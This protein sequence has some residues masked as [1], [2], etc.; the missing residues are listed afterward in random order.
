MTQIKLPPM[1]P[2]GFTGPEYEA[3]ILDIKDSHEIREEQSTYLASVDMHAYRVKVEQA[4]SELFETN[5]VLQKIRN[6]QAVS[7]QELASLNALI[8][9]QHPDVDFETL[10]NFYDSA[11]PLDQI[12]RSIIGMDAE[13]VN[14]RF[15]DFIQAYPRL[16]AKQVQFLGMLKR[17]IQKSGAIELNTLY[18]MPL[19]ALGDVDTL[20]DSDEQ[21]DRLLEIVQSFGPQPV[22]S[23]T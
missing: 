5:S 11:A 3:P 17:Q 14:S 9:T 7:D 4:L 23:T 8:H 2:A 6:G 10:K 21:I 18:E 20:F 15:A 1:N 12:L 22:R 16:S 13:A 19:A